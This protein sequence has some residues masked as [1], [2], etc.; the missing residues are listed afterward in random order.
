[1][2]LTISPNGEVVL[3]KNKGQCVTF[4]TKGRPTQEERTVMDC[5]KKRCAEL[6]KLK[7]EIYFEEG[8][9]M[10]IALYISSDQMLC[11][12]HMFP[13]TWFMDVTANL[14]RLKRDVFVM[15][16]YDA[17]GKCYVGNLTVIPSGQA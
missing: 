10:L 6:S 11:H 16:V 17:C 3:Y 1:M 13:E 7:H 2:C 8:T 4:K 5:P 15:V 14:N 9:E 12:V